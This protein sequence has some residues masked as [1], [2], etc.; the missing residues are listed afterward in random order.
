MLLLLV[1]LVGVSAAV[2]VSNSVI[3]PFPNGTDKAIHS[4]MCS[5]GEQFTIKSIICTDLKGNQIYPINPREEFILKLDTYNHGDQIDDNKVSVRIYEYETGWAGKKCRW[6][7]IPTF[8]LLKHI[9]GCDFAHNCPLTS[10]ALT[11]DLPLNLSQFSAI[12]NMLAAYKPYQLEI[13][14]Y[15]YNNKSKHEEIA[16]VMAQIEL[17]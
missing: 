8:G 16:C 10:G 2:P 17:S 11:L 7:E 13:R 5:S 15:N 9:D 14:M 12:I 3:C 1:A 4:Y 6:T